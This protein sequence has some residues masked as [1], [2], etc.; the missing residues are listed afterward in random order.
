MELSLDL[1][2]L[3]LLGVGGSLRELKRGRRREK[4]RESEGNKKEEERE[5]KEREKKEREKRK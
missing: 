2:G 5:K 3:G 4:G 1:L